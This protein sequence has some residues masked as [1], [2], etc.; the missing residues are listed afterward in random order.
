M[1]PK[2]TFSVFYTT[3][4]PERARVDSYGCQGEIQVHKC[5]AQIKNLHKQ[6]FND[7]RKW[8][9]MSKFTTLHYAIAK[10]KLIDLVQV[11][12]HGVHR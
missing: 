6:N 1:M 10:P 7:N 3:P 11:R 8:K 4:I 9:K 2:I 5:V 12:G